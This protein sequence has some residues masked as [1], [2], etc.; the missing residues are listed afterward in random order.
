MRHVR[1]GH[2]T[3][4]RVST[5]RKFFRYLQDGLPAKLCMAL[6]IIKCSR[7]LLLISINLFSGEIHVMNVVSFFDKILH[8]IKPFMR[9]EIFKVVSLFVSAYIQVNDFLKKKY[10][11]LLSAPH[12]S[13]RLQYGGL[14]PKCSPTQWFT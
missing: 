7:C 3:R 9:A 4:V 12:L 10:L 6:L 8:L 1:I 13:I 14:L 11:F 2:L 5:I